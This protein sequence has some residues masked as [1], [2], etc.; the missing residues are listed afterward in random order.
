MTRRCGGIAPLPALD[1]GAGMRS[2]DLPETL[3]HLSA[4]RAP[5]PP[6]PD[7]GCG[8]LRFI[9]SSSHCR[10]C[11]KDDTSGQKGAPTAPGLLDVFAH[12]IVIP[13]LPDYRRP[14]LF[15]SVGKA[16]S[17]R[18][19]MTLPY[20]RRNLPLL[21]GPWLVASVRPGQLLA[22]HLGNRSDEGFRRF[23]LSV[24]IPQNCRE[25]ERFEVRLRTKQRCAQSGATSR[26]GDF[27]AP[28]ASQ[29]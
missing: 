11:G 27:A 18:S 19:L 3:V 20:D 22:G 21:I 2:S 7:L 23:R 28:L 1:L 12:R 13:D 15:P 10:L 24:V 14:F 25:V 4:K 26:C 29:A 8:D 9:R 5:A 6:G 17:R 16:P